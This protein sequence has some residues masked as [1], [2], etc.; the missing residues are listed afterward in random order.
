MVQRCNS[1][2]WCNGATVPYGATVETVLILIYNVYILG[3]SIQNIKK[4]LQLL[5]SQKKQGAFP[6]QETDDSKQSLTFLNLK[7]LDG[8]NSV[9]LFQ[10]FGGG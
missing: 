9:Q 10:N 3:S 8:G 4:Q 5:E 6:D 7:I 2:I 1:P